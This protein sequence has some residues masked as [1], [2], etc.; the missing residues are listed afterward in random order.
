MITVMDYKD[1][2]DIVITVIAV[3][4]TSERV[5]QL[6]WVYTLMVDV[7]SSDYKY[8]YYDDEC[9]DW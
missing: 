8:N 1:H 7:D 3:M 9:D 2:N 6:K 4:T 5:W